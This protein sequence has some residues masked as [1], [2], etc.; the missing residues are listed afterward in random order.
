MP[1]DNRYCYHSQSRWFWANQ[2]PEERIWK[3]ASYIRGC[4]RMRLIE[5]IL[6]APVEA[7]AP[8]PDPQRPKPPPSGQMEM[9][10]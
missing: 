10:L 3:F 4:L 9:M 5:H 7:P 6:P 1:I 2:P 8:D